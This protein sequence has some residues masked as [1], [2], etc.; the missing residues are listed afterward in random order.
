MW[1]FLDAKISPFT[2]E[3]ITLID[4]NISSK[5]VKRNSAHCVKA[6]LIDRVNENSPWT[7]KIWWF[8]KK[9]CASTGIALGV[10]PHSPLNCTGKDREN[11]G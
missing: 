4:Y 11:S 10:P 9:K 5:E 1:K 3:V 2:V 7:S 6:P 8:R